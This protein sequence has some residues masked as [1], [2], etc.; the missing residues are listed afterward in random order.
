MLRS[1][2][3]SEI[4]VIET[5][6]MP[7]GSGSPEPEQRPLLLL[8]VAFTPQTLICD[9]DASAPFQ[10]RS[11]KLQVPVWALTGDAAGRRAASTSAAAAMTRFKS[12]LRY[13]GCTPMAET[14][15]HRFFQNP[16]TTTSSPSLN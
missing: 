11:V 15:S 6:G 14:T 13:R 4:N 7:G 16:A 2:A 10:L 5:W 12:I 9:D 8:I 1:R 3:C